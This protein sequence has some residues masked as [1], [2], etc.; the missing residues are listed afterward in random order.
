MTTEQTI[1]TKLDE[2]INQRRTFAI[3]SHPDAGKTTL[4]EK[5]LLY[6]NAIH[7]A[8][9]VRAR[10]NQ[11]RATSDWM[12]MEQERGISITSTV[13]QFPYK[14]HIVNLL[15][16]PGHQDFSEDTYRTLMAADSA[17]MVLDAAKGVEE[18]T[19]KLFE[20]CR[21]RG[22]PVFTFINKMD[23]PVDDPLG[24]LDEVREVLGMEPVPMNWP[25]GDGQAFKGVY[26]RAT[27]EVHLFDRSVR[28]ETAAS[29]TVTSLEDPI[30]RSGLTQERLDDFF[31]NIELLDGLG[32]DFDLESFLKGEQT[33]VY[34]GSALTNFGV[35]LFLDD[36]VQFAPQPGTYHSD[37]GPIA[38]SKAEFS[39]FVFKIQ[40]N[41]DPRHRDSVAFVRICSGRFERGMSIVEAET[42]DTTR[43]S[44]SYK[45]FADDRETVEEACAGDIIGIPGKKNFSIGATL[46]EGDRFAFDPIPRFTPE[47]FARLINNDI[48]KYK[49]FNKGLQQ[50]EREG[51]IQVL[52]DVDAMRRDPILAVVGVLQFEVM[53]ARLKNEYNVDTR[54]EHLEFRVARWLEGPEAQIE[55]LPRSPSTLQA[56]DIHGNRVTL[57]SSPFYL[58]LYRDRY[59]DIAFHSTA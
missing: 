54:L 58:D 49:Q 47:H 57:F 13:L 51:V 21:R 29:E 20:V 7:L 32:M 26:N 17:V 12:A 27:S 9:N 45:F 59:P 35:K 5:M 22:I 38:P 2:Q 23:R 33:P 36:F 16:T 11:S 40:A 43:L 6:G 42:G 44:R 18:Q 34:F 25:I 39:G 30:L 24:L 14:G 4:T 48:G 52:Y 53:Q 1:Q 3:I 56:K 15:D 8:G 31:T 28:N 10:S 41:M 50:L 37:A 19:L 55:A 46:T